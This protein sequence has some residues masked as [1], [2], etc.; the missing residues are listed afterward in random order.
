MIES[1]ASIERCWHVQSSRF[2]RLLREAILGELKN[3]D[4]VTAVSRQA[5]SLPDIDDL[6]F[7]EVALHATDRV[8]VTGNVKHY[9]PNAR[10]TVLVLSPLEAW[11]R[12]TAA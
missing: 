7:L 1:S 9:P 10:R 11:K 6:P 2:R 5:K 4:A 12:L 3:Q 8:L